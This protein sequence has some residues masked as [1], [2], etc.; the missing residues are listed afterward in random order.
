MSLEIREQILPSLQI[1]TTV[2]SSLFEL[3]DNPINSKYH[4]FMHL[5]FNIALIL[6]TVPQILWALLNCARIYKVLVYVKS[7]ANLLPRSKNYIL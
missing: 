5:Y 7:S 6:R 1:K 2:K 4:L 3:K